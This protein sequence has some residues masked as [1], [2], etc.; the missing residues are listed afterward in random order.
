MG[1]QPLQL[2]AAQILYNTRIEND[3]DKNTTANNN[4]LVARAA[5]PICTAES[6]HA[7]LA[8]CPFGPQ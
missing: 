1:P 5:N 4:S 2:S 7:K 8:P 3:S 6:D